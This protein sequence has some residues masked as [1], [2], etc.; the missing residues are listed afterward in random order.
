MVPV[1][2]IYSSRYIRYLKFES[3]SFDGNW[4]LSEQLNSTRGYFWTEFKTAEGEPWEKPWFLQ[5]NNESARYGRR[6]IVLCRFSLMCG[7]YPP[8]III[9]FRQ[10]LGYPKCPSVLV[11][12]AGT[13]DG[14]YSIESEVFTPWAPG[15]QVYKH[16]DDERLI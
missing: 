12:N 14:V 13:A 1:V 2:T 4:I 11:S 8:H 16:G 6:P 15:R 5:T 9:I 3:T 10:F 7:G